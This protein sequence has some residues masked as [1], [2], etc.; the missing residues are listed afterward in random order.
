MPIVTTLYVH[1][2]ILE[3]LNRRAVI[4][5]KSRTSIIKLLIQRVMNDNRGMIKTNSRIKYQKRDLKENSEDFDRQGK[6]IIPITGFSC[7]ALGYLKDNHRLIGCMLHPFQND[8][9]DL[10]FRVDY[11]EKCSRESCEEQKVFSGL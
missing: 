6:G 8:G 9:V 4:I 7:W 5:R 1:K 10:R 2:S 11:G 3:M